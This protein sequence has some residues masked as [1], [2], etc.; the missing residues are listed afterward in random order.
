[1]TNETEAI[2]VL[3][4]DDEQDIRDG[5]ERILTRLGF[6]VLKASRGEEALETLKNERVSMVL[7]DLKMPG[8]D[9]MEVLTRIRQLDKTILVIVITGYA[10]VETAIE[11]MKQGAYDFISKPFEPDQ[12]RIIVN[13]AAERIRLTQETEKLEQQRKRTLSDLD[14]EKSRIHTIVES[15]PNGMIV[16]NA[17]GQVVLMNPAFS[18]LLELDP[19]LKPNGP[20]EQYI[21]DQNLSQLVLE[22][23]QGKHVDYED[24]PD[25][26]F[27]LSDQKYLLA[28][29]QPVL[30]ER[31]ECLGAVV[32]VVD[33]TAMKVLDRLKSEFVAKVSHELRSPLAT[34]H[35]QLAVVLQ[36]L[37]GDGTQQEQHI[38]TRAKEKTRGLISL[39]GDLLDLSRIEE[40]LIC[41]EPQPLRLDEQLKNIVD[42]LTAQAKSKRQ[43]LILELTEE[44]LPPLTADPLALESIFG[45]LI[46]NAINYTPEGGKIRVVVDLAGI[47]VRVKII[48]NGFGIA[49]KD[50][51][52]I[53]ERFYRIKDEKTRYITGT[54]L[55]LPIV[56]G[57]LEPMGGFIEVES[58]PGKGSV[59]TV[60]LPV[61]PHDAEVEDG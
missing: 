18:Q 25:Y 34:I 36:E 15:L 20:I 1:M 24:I 59:F 10:T 55:G 48:D 41:R 30:G 40:G 2:H 60:L 13:R 44:S 57:L 43:S 37:V 28:K 51:D 12:L 52:K 14:T 38:L 8:M 17:K 46:T 9:G 7:L 54:G 27:V 23:S 45:N 6:Q 26:E 49:D 3:V 53:F 4:V 31:K 47:N 11:A 5:S 19:D 21:P 33:I 56:K 29:G 58:T 35:E 42:F 22:I 16:T 50:L 39:I 61:N 32:N